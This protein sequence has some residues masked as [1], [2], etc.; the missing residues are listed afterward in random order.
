MADVAPTELGDVFGG[1][2]TKM[3]R[4]W[5]WDWARRRVSRRDFVIPPSVA[6]TKEGSRWVVNPN[7]I[8]AEGVEAIQANRAALLS[9][10]KSLL[11]G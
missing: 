5:R 6:A 2:T 7:E 4:R 11:D 8:N 1:R 3:P 10:A 9:G